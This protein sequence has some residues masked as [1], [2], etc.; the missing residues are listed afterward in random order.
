[1]R[2]KTFFEDNARYADIINGIGG[3]G[4]QIV[5][6]ND[7]QE[8]DVTEKG[9]YRDLIR[10]VAFG[11]NFVLVGLENQETVDYRLP[12]RIMHYDVCRYEKQIAKI[13]KKKVRIICKSR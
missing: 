3:K 11:V 6:E 1:M 2:W 13:M 4:V 12:L 8:L 7:L 5:N 9:K 10:K